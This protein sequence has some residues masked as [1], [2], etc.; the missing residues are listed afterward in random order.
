MGIAEQGGVIEADLAEELLAAA[1]AF[2]FGLVFVDRQRLGDDML[3]AH[4]GIEGGVGVLKDGLDAAAEG[5]E[6]VLRNAGHGWPSKVTVPEVG[7]SRPRTM[8]AMVLLPEPDSP[9]RP[10]VSPRS[11]EKETRSTTGGASCE[12]YD[13]GEIAGDDERHS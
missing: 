9:T 2:G 8:R 13:F 7:S 3:D 11:M 4:A 6:P 10:R 5:A 1:A 12:P